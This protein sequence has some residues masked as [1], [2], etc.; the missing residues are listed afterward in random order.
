MSFAPTVS[1]LLAGPPLE[2]GAEPLDRHVARLGHLPG[3][4]I[5]DHLIDTLEAS[6]LA[7]RGGAGFSVGRKWRAIAERSEGRAIVVV[8]GA[9]GE[10]ASWKDR[11]IM[12]AR[13]Q[14]VLDGAVL[15]AEAIGADE[16]VIYVGREHRSAVAAMS[17][18]V[19]TRRASIR[20]S[21]R[22]A[23]APVGYVAGEATAAVHYI[24]AGDARP[25]S[26]PPRMSARGVADRPTLVQNVET[27]AHVA[28][29]ARFGDAWYRAIGRNDAAGTAL[30]TITGPVR[31][32][33]VR[34]IELGITLNEL[35]AQAG[36]LTT[37]VRAVVLGGYFGVWARPEDVWQLSLDPAAMEAAGTTFGCGIVGLLPNG[38]CGVEVTATIMRFMSGESAGQCGPCVLGL[39]AI[40]DA[41]SRIALGEA[42]V[43]DLAD[44]ERWVAQTSGRGA[45]RH[46]DGAA[47][48]MRSALDVFDDDFA[49]HALTGHC[50]EAL[51]PREAA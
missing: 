48:L 11:T 12:T 39:G 14:L 23:Q 22:V 33:G 6:G 34:E 50:A 47:Q 25:T 17:W 38:S 4:A 37:S 2:G 31:E 21:I 40:A 10:P 7:G 44:L 20:P 41:T 26:T 43:R 5:V 46:P 18:A 51:R 9:E 49:R 42:C 8:N 36:G 32:P 1:R 45:C 28:L 3:P 19:E 15:A 24:N 35:V 27:L 16:I 30:V 13:P 29:V